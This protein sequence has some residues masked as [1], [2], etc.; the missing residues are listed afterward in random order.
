[1][2]M[3]TTDYADPEYLDPN[4]SLKKNKLKLKYRLLIILYF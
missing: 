4:F 2:S 1:M 3:I